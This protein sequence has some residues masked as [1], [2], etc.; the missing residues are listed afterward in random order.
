MK[1][2]FIIILRSFNFHILAALVLKKT[3]YSTSVA[4]TWKI[5]LKQSSVS[6]K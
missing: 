6:L 2:I 1:I 3:M 4:K 5:V